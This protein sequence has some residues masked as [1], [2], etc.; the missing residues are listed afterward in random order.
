MQTSGKGCRENA[1]SYLRRQLSSPASD[2]E[3]KGR[4]E[5]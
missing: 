2:D 3:W 5:N 4:H 1:K